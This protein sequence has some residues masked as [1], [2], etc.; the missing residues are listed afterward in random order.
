MKRPQLALDRGN[1]RD[2]LRRSV[3]MCRICLR[4][5]IVKVAANSCMEGVQ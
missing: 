5:M 4:S 2:R 1:E 3:S